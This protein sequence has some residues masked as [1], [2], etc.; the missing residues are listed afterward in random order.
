MCQNYV[1]QWFSNSLVIGARLVDN[2]WFSDSKKLLMLSFPFWWSICMRPCSCSSKNLAACKR[3]S[4]ADV[5]FKVCLILG[6]VE[7][8]Q[9]VNLNKK[10]YSLY[11]YF[12]VFLLYIMNVFTVNGKIIW[13]S[14]V[15]KSMVRVCVQ[16]KKRGEFPIQAQL[17]NIS[18]HFSCL[19]GFSD[20]DC[21]LINDTAF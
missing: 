4:I 14:I 12:C 21:I 15:K 17:K 6:G 16:S 18:H 20:L 11:K 13:K 8:F 5:I 1:F 9:D 7:P 10:K 3:V 19:Y 2:R